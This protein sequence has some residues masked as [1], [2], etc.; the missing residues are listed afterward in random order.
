MRRHLGFI[1][2]TRVEP[3]GEPEHPSI[4]DEEPSVSLNLR[5][6]KRPRARIAPTRSHVTGLT[7]WCAIAVF[8]ISV[9]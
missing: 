1:R 2:N 4:P 5:D 7:T 3:C 9:V 8:A 6:S